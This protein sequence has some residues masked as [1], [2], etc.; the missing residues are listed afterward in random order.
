MLCEPL[1]VLRLGLPELGAT[2]PCFKM[3]GGFQFQ[4]LVWSV[5]SPPWDLIAATMAFG[6]E[7]CL[8][9]GLLLAV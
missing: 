5:C 8:S 4:M 3:F 7:C 1:A 2:F 6:L 9:V